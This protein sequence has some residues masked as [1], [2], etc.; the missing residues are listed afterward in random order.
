M[1]PANGDTFRACKSVHKTHKINGVR[2]R[3]DITKSKHVQFEILFLK[4]EEKKR[5]RYTNPV[6]KW[7]NLVGFFFFLFIIFTFFTHSHEENLVRKKSAVFC[8]CCA[9]F[10][11]PRGKRE[12]FHCCKFQKYLNRVNEKSDAYDAIQ[13]TDL[14]PFFS[15]F[16][17]RKKKKEFTFKIALYKWRKS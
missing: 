3:E 8:F 2:T 7:K 16:F 11:T 14:L 17:L 13:C 10:F 15:F 6:P 12:F 5:N 9:S 1:S 4:I